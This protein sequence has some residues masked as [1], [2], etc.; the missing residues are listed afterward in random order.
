MEFRKKL[1]NYYKTALDK[2]YDVD[3]PRTWKSVCMKCKLSCS[4]ATEDP[5]YED[6]G[7]VGRNAASSPGSN[8]DARPLSHETAQQIKAPG[9]EA[10]RNVK[11]N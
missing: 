9:D 6:G 4:G 10:G 11:S 2:C 8:S 3:D 1:Y 5:G 7:P